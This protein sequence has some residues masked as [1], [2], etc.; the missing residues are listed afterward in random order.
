M[1]RILFGDNQFFG[2]NHQSEEKA[3]AQAMQFKDAASIM[4]VLD[5]AHDAGIKVF[6]CTTHDR[7][8][9]IADIVRANPQRYADF[10]F[11]P[12]MPYAHKYANS[13]GEVGIIDTL[14]RFAPGGLAETLIKGA[15][16][17]M[18]QD[19]ERLMQ[20]LVD[21]EMK[22]F[23]GLDTPVVFIQNVVTDLLLGLKLYGMFAAFARHVQD[24]YRVE[25]GFITMNLPLLVDA[26]EQ[27]GIRNP[28]V[29]A[30]VNKIGFRMSGGVGAYRDL[31]RSGRCRTIA[32]S[33]FASG[34]IPPK[35]AIE[36]VCG[37]QGLQSI[38]F[39]ASSAGNIRQSK[40]LIEQAWGTGPAR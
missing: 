3:R 38:V 2:I 25:P 23:A 10:K 8:G 14:R 17:A 26:L 40:A 4:R 19:M 18:T 37:L 30:N 33:I 24:K 20:L 35:E 15:I 32:M 36:W 28:I 39:G 5:Q 29:C 27:V 1:D 31:I 16:S 9:E 7:I 13:V 22:R 21:A 12:C 11:Y 6:M 34:A